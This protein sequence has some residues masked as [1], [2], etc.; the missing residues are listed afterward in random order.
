[1]AAGALLG[2]LLGPDARIGPFDPVRF[3]DFLGTLF[4]NLLK[5]LIVPLISSSIIT[6]VAALGSGRDLGRLGLK[7][8]SFYVITTLIAVLIALAIINV[9]QPGIVNGSPRSTC[10]RSKRMRER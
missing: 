1:M 7:T 10:W 6:S 3:F 9:V 4:I 5:M 8:L 2:W